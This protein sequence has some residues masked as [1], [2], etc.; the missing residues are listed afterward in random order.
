MKI[1]DSNPSLIDSTKSKSQLKTLRLLER[2]KSPLLHIAS[3]IPQTRNPHSHFPHDMRPYAA[4]VE[5]LSGG[6]FSL[7]RDQQL[8]SHDWTRDTRLK[9]LDHVCL[10]YSWVSLTQLEQLGGSEKCCC[11][12][13]EPMSIS[14][15]GN[16]ITSMQRFTQVRTGGRIFYNHRN[17]V[18]NADIKDVFLF[19]CITPCKGLPYDSTFR[20]VL[21]TPN[22]GCPCCEATDRTESH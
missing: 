5:K 13:G 11:Y 16:D 20:E 19:H 4:Q 3:K 12:C 17:K 14:H 6:R 21:N 15:I 7:A 8:N 9:L 18:E 22:A 2:L 10:Q 1:S